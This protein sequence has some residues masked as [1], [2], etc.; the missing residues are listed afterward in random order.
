[1]AGH[2][3]HVGKA[4]DNGT[5]PADERQRGVTE[6]IAVA[7]IELNNVSLFEPGMSRQIEGR[8]VKK[9]LQ[10]QP[11]QGPI[12]ESISSFQTWSRD[13]LNIFVVGDLETDQHSRVNS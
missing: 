13:W 8:G 6:V 12:K 1:M 11:S 2:G 3:P 5:S 9:I 4:P 7:V 10:T